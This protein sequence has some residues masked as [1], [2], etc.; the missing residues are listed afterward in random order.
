MGDSRCSAR[1]RD[2]RGA[3]TLGVGARRASARSGAIWSA[4]LGGGL[5]LTLPVASAPAAP[6]AT[7]ASASAAPPATAGSPPEASPAPAAVAA[8]RTLV[9]PPTARRVGT[10]EYVTIPILTALTL[11]VVLLPPDPTEARL[12]GPFLFDGWVRDRLRAESASGR[13]TAHD[14][15]D[16]LALVSYSQPIVFDLLVTAWAA[17]GAPDAAWQMAVIDAQAYALTFA[18]NRIS[19]RLTLRERPWGEPCDADPSACGQSERH[20]SF[21]SA[22]AAGTA[23]NAGL[24]CAHHTQLELYGDP[25]LDGGACAAAVLMSVTTSSLR[26]VSDYHWASDVLVGLLVGSASGYLVPTLLYYRGGKSAVDER[27]R[28]SRE[29]DALRVG[30]LPVLTPESAQLVLLGQL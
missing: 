24:V 11:G 4:L 13:K 18:L 7:A 3:A 10:R 22:H 28:Q 9:W 5:T 12:R 15:S 30:V 6:S 2:L 1:A 29:R 16:V 19:K 8:K 14:V 26:I 27:S 17:R 20:S 21:F 25:L 23:T